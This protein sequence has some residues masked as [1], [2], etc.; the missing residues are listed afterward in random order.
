M[1]TEKSRGVSGDVSEDA[2][3]TFMLSLCLRRDYS[4]LNL[5]QGSPV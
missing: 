4:D 2:L 5:V 3:L 1:R